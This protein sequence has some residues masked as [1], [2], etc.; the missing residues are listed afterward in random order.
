V[1]TLRIDVDPASCRPNDLAEAV[2]FLRSGGI[3]AFPTDTLYGLAV[4]PTSPAAVAR[5]FALKGR[6]TSAAV[7]F[8]AASREQVEAW[9][10]MSAG[11][12]RLADAFWPGPL[13]LICNAPGAIVPAI[14]AQLGT[15]AVRV[16]AHPVA[17]ALASAWGSPLPATSANISGQPPAVRAEELAALAS[18]HLLV[19]DA[20]P[21]AGG[22]PSTIVDARQLLPV[23]VREGAIAWD[24]V[25]DSLQR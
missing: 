16:P 4:D 21:A 14:H 9:T 2:S 25:L 22:A 23:L 7:P 18:E 6:P 5:L 8:V 20:G 1:P 24:R 13:S 11:A 3:V 15:V 17:R 12:A 19:I 10:A